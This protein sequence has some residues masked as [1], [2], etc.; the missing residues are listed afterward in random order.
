[1]V[2]GRKSPIGPR[3][4]TE[5]TRYNPDPARAGKDDVEKLHL[6]S[7]LQEKSG[8]YRGASQ[9]NND[10]QRRHA[11]FSGRTFVRPVSAAV[12]LTEC[13]V[14]VQSADGQ[15]DS[16]K[17]PLRRRRAAAGNLI[18]R[19]LL[20][21]QPLLEAEASSRSAWSGGWDGDGAGRK[22]FGHSRGRS[23]RFG[24]FNRLDRATFGLQSA[25]PQAMS[26]A[27]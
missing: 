15:D 14:T 22:R 1:M 16:R 2:T 18:A 25:R 5:Q 19:T 21:A 17:K 8:H 24:P 12:K 9:P 7:E 26:Q 27:R 3:S 4:W 13:C 11:G 20:E 6:W 10:F 23:S